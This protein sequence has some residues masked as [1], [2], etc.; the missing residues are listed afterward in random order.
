MSV[1]DWL[2]PERV[3]KKYKGNYAM[4]IGNGEYVID[5]DSYILRRWHPHEVSRVWQVCPICLEYSK[6]LTIQACT[7]LEW[8]YSNIQIVFS[9]RNGFH[10]H[11]LDFNV[12]DWTKRSMKNLVKWHEV[13]RFK[14][15]Q[16][17]RLNTYCLD[18]P[19]FIF[20]VDPMRVITVPNTLNG[21]TG[22]QCIHIGTRKHLEYR[23]IESI[24]WKAQPLRERYGCEY[25]HGYPEPRNW[26]VKHCA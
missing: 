19:R 10:I 6:R 20:S 9:G 24:L 14:F 25:S 17:I 7:R 5:I 4:P 1:L 8:Y 12:S 26:A 15:S 22:L 2:F 13:A 23:T 11:V 18:R 16:L 21:D 3:G